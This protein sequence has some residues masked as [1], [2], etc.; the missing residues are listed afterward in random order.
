VPSPI[1]DSANAVLKSGVQPARLI[2]VTGAGGFIGQRVVDH[3]S[4]SGFAV[5]AFMRKASL[6]PAGPG[7]S[8]A[9]GDMT[10]AASVDRAIAGCSAVVHLAAA[11]QDERWSDDVNTGGAQRLVDACRR[12]GCLRV[13][14]I[15]TQ[16]V[17]I[18]RKGAYACTKAAADALFRASGLEVTTLFPSLVYGGGLEAI[19]GTL[20]RTVRGLPVVP[21]LGNGRW[22]SAPVDV[23]DVAAA[24]V[25]CL[26]APLTIGR[27]Y[28]LGGPS[29][30]GFDELLD[31]IGEAV[32]AGARPK[33]HVPLPL[34]LVAARVLALLLPSPPISVS[35]VL[36]SNQDT[37]IDIGPAAR[38][39]GFA[40][41]EFDVGLT[42]AF[43]H[44]AEQQDA[45]LRAEARHLARYLVR[46]APGD[47]VVERY[48]DAHHRLF[49][50]PADSVT[51]WT[52]RHPWT[53]SVL[54]AAAGLWGPTPPLRQR[55]LLMASILEATPEYADVY[56]GGSLGS[57]RALATIA[58][59]ACAA[60]ARAVVGMPLY[61]FLRS[62]A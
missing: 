53:L 14:N 41:I 46:R 17:R 18:P 13:I 15:S 19:F 3:L 50:S 16:S 21:V 43:P 5:R 42:R 56:L 29:L 32:G 52:R 6:A 24:I 26:G 51:W 35:N 9:L 49:A 25:A 12:N 10:D 23:D 60:G 58:W 57:V 39:F 2:L 30:I 40:P 37:A 48:V 4:R 28:D 1:A 47:D 11:K 44:A 38:D 62:S 31:R 20:A 36:G 8:I 54:D 59:A 22:R 45:M 34:A 55:V 27:E 7:V 33:L 61:L